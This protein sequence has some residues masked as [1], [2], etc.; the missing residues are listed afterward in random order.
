MKIRVF[1]ALALTI[2]LAAFFVACDDGST[3]PELPVTAQN[4]VTPAPTAVPP[5][6]TPVPPTNTRRTSDKY[7]RATYEHTRTSDKY[8]RAAYK[9][10][11]ASDC[12]ADKHTC[13]ADQH[14]RAANGN[15]YSDEHTCADSDTGTDAD[16]RAAYTNA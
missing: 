8:A 9:H 5:T 13:A 4:Q 16:A 12:D 15:T 6:N 7:A 1:V 2:F 3:Q 14:T 10:A 11:R